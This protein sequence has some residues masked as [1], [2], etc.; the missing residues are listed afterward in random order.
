[1]LIFR[2]RST[3]GPASPRPEQRVRPKTEA[4]GELSW[5]FF[6]GVRRKVRHAIESLTTPRR[7]AGATEAS[8]GYARRV[9]A[10]RSAVR[11]MAVRRPPEPAGASATVNGAI[12]NPRARPA[13]TGAAC[14]LLP[15]NGFAN[16]HRW[17][18][19]LPPAHER[20]ANDLFGSFGRGHFGLFVDFFSLVT[21]TTAAPAT[22]HQAR[23]SRHEHERDR[24]T[25]P[26]TPR[27]LGPGRKRVTFGRG[28]LGSSATGFR[29]CSN[30]CTAARPWLAW[31]CD[32]ESDRVPSTPQN[33]GLFRESCSSALN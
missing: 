12:V 4:V 7:V 22:A 19:Q 17:V 6:N 21:T 28:H 14:K 11:R 30:T 26:P 31:G 1:M 9:R 8:A 5:D 18:C 16:D 25:H 29:D 10:G 23:R 20:A 33:K 3:S 32:D 15:G 27:R 13:R 2:R 24:S